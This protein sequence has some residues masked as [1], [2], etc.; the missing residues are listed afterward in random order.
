M[1]R[2]GTDKGKVYITVVKIAMLCGLERMALTKKSGDRAGGGR[3][4]N[5]NYIVG[6]NE[7]E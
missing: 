7:N 6:S 2:K 1:R 3:I 5:T 4:E